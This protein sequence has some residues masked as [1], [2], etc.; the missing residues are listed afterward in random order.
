[1]RLYSL[2]Y[3]DIIR[4]YDGQSFINHDLGELC[5]CVFEPWFKIV[6]SMIFD[7]SVSTGQL[8]EKI[9]KCNLAIEVPSNKTEY[10]QRFPRLENAST[11]FERQV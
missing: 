10:C 4:N 6:S 3:D 9:L 2:A 11:Q 7:P 8:V 5:Q 1:V